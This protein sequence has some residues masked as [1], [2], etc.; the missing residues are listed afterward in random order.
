MH[1]TYAPRIDP[2]S[3]PVT[4]A[5]KYI[6]RPGVIEVTRET[7][8]Q[9]FGKPAPQKADLARDPQ[10]WFDADVRAN[11]AAYGRQVHY[12]LVLGFDDNNTPKHFLVDEI[13]DELP[14]A[15]LAFYRDYGYSEVPFFDFSGWTVT[16]EAAQ[17][18]NLASLT[19][20]GMS[21]DPVEWRTRVHVPMPLAAPPENVALAFFLGTDAVQLVN[22]EAYRAAHPRAAATSSDQIS[23]IERMLTGVCRNFGL[24]TD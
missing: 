4:C 16:R 8:P 1:L 22:I 11:P 13:K 24:A 19:G 15:V 3:L 10:G 12:P 14:P 7:Y 5:L 2:A 20:A 17:T 9:Y 18:P 23:H 21:A 6:Y